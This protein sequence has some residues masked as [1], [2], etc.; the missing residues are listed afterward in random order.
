MS[1]WHGIGTTAHVAH[2]SV[3]LQC[4]ELRG[5][6]N[7]AT[8]VPRAVQTPILLRIAFHDAG[9][10]IASDREGG[11]NGSTQFELN[12][13]HNRS[14]VRRFGWPVVLRVRC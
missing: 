6:T 7:C 1:R 9:T 4:R 10:Y 2:A 14:V 11:P 12:R 3:L 5:H 13:V 8:R